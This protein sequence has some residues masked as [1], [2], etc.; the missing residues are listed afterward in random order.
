[1]LLLYFKALHVLFMVSWFAGLFF[2]GRMLI[3]EQAARELNKTDAA[4]QAKDGARR[5]WY[6]ITLPSMI[7][8]A[9]FGLALAGHIGAFREGWFHLKL[10][11]VI[12]F[13]FYNLYINR[14][15]VKLINNQSI[16][17]GWKLRVLNEV[18]FFFMV[19]I[20]F[21]VYLKDLFNGIWALMVLAVLVSLIGMVMMLR[22]KR[23][24]AKTAVTGDTQ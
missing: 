19:G 24:L 23:R 9:F 7:L 5:V 11:M 14:L 12:A 17:A 16:P 20:I 4:T 18:P 2:M 15:R 8:T 13:V 1:M 10:M 21:T 3:Y 22:K 6:I